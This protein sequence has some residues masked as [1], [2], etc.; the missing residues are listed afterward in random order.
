MSYLFEMLL[1]L[2]MILSGDWE[3]EERTDK[4][5]TITVSVDTGQEQL[6]QVS[7][8][9]LPLLYP[10]IVQL[11]ELSRSLTFSVDILL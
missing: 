5:I 4:I 2:R 10:E 1:R 11:T 3:Q 6:L 8:S 9:Y 7:E